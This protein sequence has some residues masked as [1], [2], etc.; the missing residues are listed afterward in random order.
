MFEKITA[1]WTLMQK[2]KSVADPT[3]WK[4]GAVTTNT[5]VGVLGAIAVFAKSFG[6]DLHVTD[7]LLSQL[8][9]AVLAIVGA[10]NAVVH[11]ITDV[12]LGMSGGGSSGS[13]GGSGAPS[14]PAV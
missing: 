5:L 14:A 6:Y 9:G 10:V 8:A 11:V 12:R 2:G 3:A 4:S 1:L 7:G 13:T